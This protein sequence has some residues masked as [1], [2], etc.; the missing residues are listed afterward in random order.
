MVIA[1]PALTPPTPR[2]EGTRPMRGRGGTT[3]NTRSSPRVRISGAVGFQGWFPR[4]RAADCRG[5]RGD[6][7]FAIRDRF[8]YDTGVANTG[9]ATGVADST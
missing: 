5:R 9:L 4:E 1:V 6:A 7:T 3:W 8:S 2:P